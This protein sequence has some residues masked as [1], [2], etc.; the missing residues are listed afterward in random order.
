MIFWEN[1]CSQEEG[2]HTTKNLRRITRHDTAPFQRQ[3]HRLQQNAVGKTWIRW[4]FYTARLTYQGQIFI[5]HAWLWKRFFF[6]IIHLIRMIQD[7]TWWVQ[8]PPSRTPIYLSTAM[9]PAWLVL[10]SSL[11][12][13]WVKVFIKLSSSV[14]T[15][16][17]CPLSK[18]VPY[19][20]EAPVLQKDSWVSV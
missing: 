6:L 16:P 19:G 8:G 14:W 3:H 4:D 18:K 20:P 9:Q 2:T 5:L 17:A 15:A 7:R 1:E 12:V 10:F 13:H 11:F